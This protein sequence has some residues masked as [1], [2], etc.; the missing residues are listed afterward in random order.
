[1]IIP[2]DAH[3]TTDSYSPNAVRPKVGTRWVWE[4]DIPSARDLIEVTQVKWNGEE[5]WVESKTL[6]P[7]HQHRFPSDRC[8]NELGRFWEACLPVLP[9][10]TG[11]LDIFSEIGPPVKEN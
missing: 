2:A 4:I 10:I 5:W 1:M 9:E 7:P 8:W 6:L 3:I 11:R